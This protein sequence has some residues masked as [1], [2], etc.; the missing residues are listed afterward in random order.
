MKNRITIII[1]FLISGLKL[2]A[3]YDSFIVHLSFEKKLKGVDSFPFDR[4]VVFDNRFDTTKLCIDPFG[5][6]TLLIEKFDNPASIAIED[7]IQSAIKELPK[8]PGTLYISL[9]QLRFGN[10]HNLDNT[11]FFAADAYYLSNKGYKK[12]SSVRKMYTPQKKIRTAELIRS[13][14]NDLIKQINDDHRFG[15]KQ[16][17]A[18]QIEN[19]N[20][21]VT[22]DWALY[23]IIATSHDTDGVY[24]SLEE[25]QNNKIT[26]IDFLLSP[27]EDSTFRISFKDDN[28]FYNKKRKSFKNIWAVSYH[29]DLYLPVLGKYFLPLLKHDNRFY[30]YVP[31]ALPDMHEIIFGGYNSLSNSSSGFTSGAH[32]NVLLYSGNAKLAGFGAILAFVQDLSASKKNKV[33]ADKIL[34]SPK[35]LQEMRYCFIDMDTGDII[36]Y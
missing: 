32:D 13:A 34:N 9:K 1:F 19:V 23:P 7:Y 12:V 33:P 24:R 17:L 25:F 27:A 21:P 36:F 31:H 29:G 14:M 26:T 15:D 3:Q 10:L 22:A 28:V 4:I 11:L 5:G 35:R 16:D 18:Y 2:Y 20:A 6:N 30:F 8:Q